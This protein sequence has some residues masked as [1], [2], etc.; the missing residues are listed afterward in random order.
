MAPAWRRK[1]RRIGR[2][3][4]LAACAFVLSMIPVVRLRRE[5]AARAFVMLMMPRVRLC[6]RHKQEKR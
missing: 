6:R 5:F 2:L 4:Q 3:S 1:S